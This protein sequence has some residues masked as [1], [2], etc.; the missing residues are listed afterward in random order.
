MADDV[1]AEPGDR[2]GPPPWTFAGS[3][4]R[5]TAVVVKYWHIVAAVVVMGVA[6]NLLGNAVDRWPHDVGGLFAAVVLLG[7]GLT[8]LVLG[9]PDGNDTVIVIGAAMWVENQFSSNSA[10]APGWASWVILGALTLAIG[11]G[12]QLS[13]TRRAGRRPGTGT[14]RTW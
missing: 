10:T 1:G 13:R 5:T 11:G 8:V 3:W 12:R 6:G 7:L 2:E 4:A 14:S 9:A